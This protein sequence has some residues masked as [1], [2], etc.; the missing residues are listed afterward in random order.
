MGKLKI[1]GD[2]VEGGLG[3]MRNALKAEDAVNELTAAER[4]AGVHYADPLA[5]ATMRMS[6]A[7]G[8]AGAEGKTLNF[9]E[10]DRSRVF[11]SNRGGVGFSGLQNYSLPHQEANTVWGFGNKTTAEKKVK[12]NDPKKNLFTTFVGSP[13]QHKSNTV[14]LQDAVKE[15]QDAVKAGKVHPEQINL[16]NKRLKAATDEDSGALLFG[17]DFDLR[18]PDVLS[19]ANSFNRRAAIGDVMLGTGVRKQM[20]SRAFKDEHGA[21]AFDDAGK[22]E[23]ILKRETDPDLINANTY[24]VGN[25]LFVLDNGIIHRP[26]LN[27][28]FPYQVTGEDLGMKYQ[29]VPPE[30]AMR[31]FYKMREGR[32]NKNG[33]PSPVSYYDLSRAQPSQMVDEDYLTFLQNEGLK[34]GGK[35]GDFDA[36]VD[37][38][39]EKHHF[40]NHINKRI[41]EHL[42]K[43]GMPKLARTSLRMAGGGTVK[44]MP[45]VEVKHTTLRNRKTSQAQPNRYADG[46]IT[47][48]HTSLRDMGNK[49]EATIQ[50]TPR[51]KFLGAASDLLKSGNEFVS[52][53]FGYNNP[54]AEMLSDFVGIPAA[55]RVLD[56]LSY[57]E[58]I[59]NMGKA[60]VPLIPE[61]TFD[62]AGA[63]L[64]GLGSASKL[65]KPLAKGLKMLPKDLPV[66]MSIKAVDGI[67]TGAPK[68]KVRPPSDNVANVRD[69]NFQYPKTIGNQTL[70]IDEV[71]GG[72][73]S[74]N[75]HERKRVKELADQMSSPDGYISRIIV[76]HN[77]NVIEGQ[78]R[79]EALRQLGVEDVPVYKI[80]DLADTMP[81]SKMEEAM[82]EAGGI[83]SD[84]VNQLMQHALDDISEGGIEGAR[85]L[86]YGKFQKYYD[87][88]LNAASPEVAKA[89]GGAI[90]KH[91]TLRNR[92]A[93]QRV[94]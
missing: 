72:V 44:P 25:R 13:N 5:P 52:K 90:L 33:D 80:E 71:S 60:N 1:L 66:G 93:N 75:P 73:R 70:K 57:G 20:R 21:V 16:M 38:L 22:M 7:L 28:A 77:N 69:A 55:S 78:H 31:D 29:L 36:K 42:A 91:H 18:D 92:R 48:A 9:T 82:R 8:N 34:D 39:I 53:P 30:K 83:H 74:T 94:R 10:A 56:K 4:V 41:E 58:P 19:E 81:V 68:L 24:D 23:S 86:D 45:K 43:G 49:N 61:D 51:N 50:A 40:D 79:L 11:G 65:A 46:G 17:K 27:V 88:A 64:G 3:M 35:V 85:K 15:F 84:H 54:P 89:K 63:L 87:A 67:P 12:Q 14:V 47:L 2:V 59:T 6:E 37:R 32:L 62:A 26:D 76:D